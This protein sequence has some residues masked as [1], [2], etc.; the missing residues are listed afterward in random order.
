MTK[1]IRR[2][3]LI[4]MV[5]VG[6]IVVSI[7]GAA[8]L[9]SGNIATEITPNNNEAASQNPFPQVQSTNLKFETRAIPNDLD[10]SVQLIVVAYD[11]DQQIYVD[12]WLK[13]LE[14]LNER[15]PDLNGYYMPL[16]PRDAADGA[17][18]IIGGMAL[19]AESN[20]NRERT[21]VTFTDVDAFN[22][23]VGVL[24][25][26]DVQLFLLDASQQIVWHGSGEYAPA[27]LA[28]LEA[29]LQTVYVD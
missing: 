6:L 3:L 4:G 20:E 10:G 19:V 11:T 12:K 22:D 21:L 1:T 5:L 17:L 27:T 13:P 18:F 26:N 28:S 2:F 23:Q 29:A 8:A 14:D 24:D 25:K 7:S 9:F 15:Y 16:L